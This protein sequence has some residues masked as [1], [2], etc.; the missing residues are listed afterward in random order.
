MSNSKKV[1][2][3]YPYLKCSCKVFFHTQLDLLYVCITTVGHILF[4]QTAGK[5][6]VGLSIVYTTSMY[7]K[8]PEPDGNSL[9]TYTYIILAKHAAY[10]FSLYIYSIYYN[11]GIF[12]V[13]NIAFPTPVPRKTGQISGVFSCNLHK[14]V[15]TY[16]QH[17]FTFT[18]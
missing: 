18:L 2:S 17:C 14:Y 15:N 1:C 9:L 8:Q 5:Y 4:P 13:N 11:L 6:R 7:S 10:N 3:I 16:R 12:T